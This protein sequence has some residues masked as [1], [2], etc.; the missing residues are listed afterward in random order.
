MTTEIQIGLAKFAALHIQMA[1]PWSC[2][3]QVDDWSDTASFRV[4]ITFP[5]TH[6]GSR[7]GLP[8]YQFCDKVDLRKAGRIIR[9]ALNAKEIEIE[10]I[11]MPKRC[12]KTIIY[13]K[14]PEGYDAYDIQLDFRVLEC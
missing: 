4:F 5:F 11:V 10:K 1:M 14:Y 9:K 3:V 12:Y 6:F 8:R 2:K 7:H 13:R